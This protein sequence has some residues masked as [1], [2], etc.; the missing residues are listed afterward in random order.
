MTRY[1]VAAALALAFLAYLIVP[2]R[3]EQYCAELY[4]G[5]GSRGHVVCAESKVKVSTAAKRK[6]AARQRRGFR[7]RDILGVGCVSGQR[8][9]V[10]NRRSRV[11]DVSPDA[12]AIQFDNSGRWPASGM[13]AGLASRIL[14]G[15]SSAIG[16]VDS[17]LRDL[18]TAAAGAAGV[19]V[20]IAHG[21]VKVESGYRPHIRG[22]AG[23]WGMGQIKCPTARSVGFSGPCNELARPETNLRF[24]MAYLRLALDRGGTSCG[25]VSLYNR[26]IHARPVCTGYGRRVMANARS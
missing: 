8:C 10:H 20:A 15:S 22:A 9:G 3:S 24:S 6:A 2:A 12:V 18:V 4:L 14:E 19:P 7:Q 5:L 26:G 1:H 23:E 17:G 11:A 21:V 25:G 16:A 13:V